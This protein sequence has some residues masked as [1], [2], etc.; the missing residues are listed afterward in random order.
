MSFVLNYPIGI[1][2]A[3]NCAS[4]LEGDLLEFVV[5][6]VFVVCVR[7]GAGNFS[8]SSVGTF[9]DCVARDFVYLSA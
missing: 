1:T 4:I 7:V 9:D 8:Y 3:L 2:T 5:G 6:S